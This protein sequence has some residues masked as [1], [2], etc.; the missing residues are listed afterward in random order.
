MKLKSELAVS[1]AL[2]CG[3]LTITAQTSSP[4]LAQSNAVKVSPDVNCPVSLHAQHLPDGDVIKTAADHPKGLGQRL[5]LTLKPDSGTA[6]NATLAIHGTTPKGRIQQ[7][8]T[9][10]VHNDAVQTLTVQ[11]IAAKDGSSSAAL[12]VPGFTSVG[13]IE[14][15]A[16]IFSDGSTWKASKDQVCHVIYDL[17]LIAQH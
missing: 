13:E 17:M 1:I 14:V 4:L 3:S 7:T 8:A 10:G 16:M 6:V 5:H 11:F 12:W 2:F 9:D 15:R